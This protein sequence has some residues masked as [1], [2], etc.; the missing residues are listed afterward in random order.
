VDFPLT[1]AAV[2]RLDLRD[3]CPSTNSELADL[4][5]AGDP[6]AYTTVLTFTQTAG[7]GRLG[8]TWVAPP[9]SAAAISVLLVLPDGIAPDLAGWL[10]LAAGLAM[11]ET[12]A[13]ELPDRVV[14]LK[15]PNDVLVGDR[16]ISGILAD[17]VRPGRVVLGAGL[18]VSIAPADLPVPTATSLAIEGAA[19]GDGLEDRVVAGYLTRLRQELDA[20][21]A[22]GFDA[23]RSGLADRVARRSATLGR[24]VRVEL[25][26]GSEFTG[27]ASALDDT[28]RLRVQ[29]ASGER[30]VSAGDVRHVRGARGLAG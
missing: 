1:A 3:S 27:T 21:E 6:P 23:R 22:S 25:P 10:P 30:V 19:T 26:D 13:A 12:V 5:R 8:R 11:A 14:G 16:K 28:G 4:V 2:P 18:N 15:W 24:E 7:R 20:L 9:G 29:T 17:L